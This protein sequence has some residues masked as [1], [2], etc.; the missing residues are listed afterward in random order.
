LLTGAAVIEVLN[1]HYLETGLFHQP[2]GIKLRVLR[3]IRRRDV[4]RPTRMR[5]AAPFAIGKNIQFDL[6]HARTEL[7]IERPVPILERV[8]KLR[9]LLQQ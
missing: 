6:A 4:I 2:F 1:V 8:V 3:Q 9:I 5:V 7:L